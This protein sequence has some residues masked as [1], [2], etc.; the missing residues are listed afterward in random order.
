[1]RWRLCLDTKNSRAEREEHQGPER[2]SR[3]ED[4][5]VCD[6]HPLEPCSVQTWEENNIAPFLIKWVSNLSP[7]I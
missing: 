5:N 2:G 7:T 1:M 6:L 3:E 4:M